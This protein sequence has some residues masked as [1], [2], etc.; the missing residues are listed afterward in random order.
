MRY[1]LVLMFFLIAAPAAA[2]IIEYEMDY[3]NV[4]A[5]APF[6]TGSV[7]GDD[8][9]CVDGATLPEVPTG[10]VVNPGIAHLEHDWDQD[11]DL[12]IC[13]FDITATVRPLMVGDYF[14]RAKARSTADPT[15]VSGG[16]ADSNPFSNVATPAD[17]QGL[18]IT[19]N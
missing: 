7:M 1:L 4:G 16:S 17:P 15:L 19:R 6:M 2:Q 14:G 5:S 9:D 8:S 3:F 13:S 11:G 10:N 12:D 18:V